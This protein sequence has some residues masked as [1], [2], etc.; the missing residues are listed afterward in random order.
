MT[1]KNM[2]KILK[3]IEYSFFCVVLLLFLL[4]VINFLS[5]KNKLPLS[6]RLFSVQSGSMAP[7]VPVGGIVITSKSPSYQKG[8]IIS[9][10]Q[11]NNINNI[12]THRIHS[13]NS[14]KNNITYKTKGDANKSPDTDTITNSQIIGK[15]IFTLP[16]LG[17]FTSYTQSLQG[18]IFFIIIPATVLVYHE[19]LNLKKEILNKFSKFNFQFS[20]NSL[21]KISVNIS[22]QNHI[23]FINRT[24]IL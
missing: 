21:N 3:I 19:L 8:D 2:R 16:F 24:Y 14:Q 18:L 13:I 10:L 11:N 6:V 4:C 15:V 23:T 1:Q 22:K 7:R 17:F 12:V 20:I 5:V 9:F